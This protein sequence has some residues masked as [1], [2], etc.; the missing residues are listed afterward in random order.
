MTETTFTRPP[1]GLAFRALLRADTIVLLRSTVATVLS[2][3]LPIVILIATTLGKAGSRL[4][5]P[6]IIIGLALTLR[7]IT[8]CL[9]G[10]SLTLAPYR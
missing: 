8:S 10:Y 4:G 7:L 2:L 6:A 3:V 9:L 1:V 5:S